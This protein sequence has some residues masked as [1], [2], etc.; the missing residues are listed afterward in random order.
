MANMRMVA[1]LC[2][3]I[4]GTQ[5]AIDDSLLDLMEDSVTGGQTPI[6]LTLRL[7]KHEELDE[8]ERKGS[9]VFLMQLMDAMHKHHD[10]LQ[11]MPHDDTAQISEAKDK[12]GTVEE[13]QGKQKE[14]G[15]GK[16]LQLTPVK[17]ENV[18]RTADVKLLNYKQTQYVGE[19][20]VGTPPQPF[21]VIFDTGSGNLWVYGKGSDMYGRRE[22]EPKDSKTWVGTGKS[23]TISYAGGR[24]D[25]QIARDTVTLGPQVQVPEQYFGQTYSASGGLGIGDGVMGLG[26]QKLAFEGT[27]VLIDRLLS[28]SIAAK[29]A[30]SFYFT[31]DE[32][33]KLAELTFGGAKPEHFF[34]NF[35]WI[36]MISHHEPYWTLKLDDILVGGK[37]MGF[38]PGGCKIVVDTGSSFF[39]GPSQQVAQI[40]GKTRVQ[41]DCS[42]KLSLPSIS[43]VLNGRTFEMNADDYV[44]VHEALGTCVTTFSGLDVEPPRGPLWV[45]GDVFIR[46]FYTTFDIRGMRVGFAQANHQ[47]MQTNAKMSTMPL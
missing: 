2:L 40:L 46:K 33:T 32:N 5:A 14:S 38:C 20:S 10:E 42:N 28:E 3:L 7:H 4:V 43:F 23:S 16:K 17:S 29:P 24:V 13:L 25:C 44:L 47:K 36:P 22:F 11:G 15:K 30:F 26:F 34:G 9:D 8:P 18:V 1:I 21:R 41:R 45:L 19:I 31:R 37:S 39:S 6:S 27:T 35:T 12:S